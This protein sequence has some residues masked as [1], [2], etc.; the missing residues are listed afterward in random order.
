MCQLPVL[1]CVVDFL[2]PERANADSPSDLLRD[3]RVRAWTE[4]HRRRHGRHLNILDPSSLLLLIFVTRTPS[5]SLFPLSS[6]GEK[7]P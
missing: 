6:F 2:V 1:G 5:A 4:S 3:A 7:A